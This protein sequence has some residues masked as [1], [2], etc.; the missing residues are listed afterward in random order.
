MTNPAETFDQ[1]YARIS[2]TRKA[3]ILACAD[4]VKRKE[5]EAWDQHYEEQY[6]AAWQIEQARRAE[7]Q[8]A[9]TPEE[10]LERRQQHQAENW[11]RPQVSRD[12][13]TYRVINGEAS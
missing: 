1:F 11:N 10:R 13:D 12:N 8:S 2:A 4:P 7:F 9:V 5:L 6:R 3:E